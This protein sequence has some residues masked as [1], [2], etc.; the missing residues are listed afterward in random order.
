MTDVFTKAQRSMV[1]AR[2]RGRDNMSTEIRVAGLMRAAKVAGWRRHS[3]M[4][5][6]PDFVFQRARV[7]LFVDGCFWH[8]CPRCNRVPASSASF[9]RAKIQRNKGRDKEVNR[10][11]RKR[12]WNVVRVRECQLKAP[13]RFLRRLKVLTAASPT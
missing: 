10:Q 5:G 6:K 2:V 9:W 7:A 8:G 4:F 3:R 11:L 13:A 12:G 1:M